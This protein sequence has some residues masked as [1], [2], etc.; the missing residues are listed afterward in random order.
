MKNLSL[1]NIAAACGGRYVGTAQAASQE[2]TGIETDSRKVPEGGMFVAIKG[3]RVD[4]HKFIEQVMQGGAATVLTEI[5]LGEKPYPYILVESTLQAVKDIA[6]FYL[7]GLNIPVVG[8]AGSVGKTSTKEM[9]HSVLSQG[10]NALK[11][12]GNFNNELGLPIT[13]FRL[14]DEQLAVLEMGISDF[15]EMHRL[16]KVARPHTVIMTNIGCCHLENLIDRDGILRAKSEIFD[17]LEPGAHIILNGDDDK[18]ATVTEVRGIKPV[19]FGLDAKNDFWAS[20]LRSLGLKGTACRIHTPVGDFDAT[21]GM[22]GKH[23]VYNALAGAAAGVAYGLTL[24]QIKAGIESNGSLAGRFNIIDTERYTIIDD[25]YNANPV[26]MKASLEVLQDGANRRVAI[27]GDMGELG[28][29][30]RALHA[31]VGTYAAGL[32]LDAIYC[33]GPLCEALVQAAADGGFKG[34][35]KHYATRDDLMAALPA[36]LQQGDTILVK[37][38]HFMQFPAIVEMLK[39]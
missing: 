38:S 27:L 29:D 3:E 14:R 15:G 9:T 31:G 12:Q 5:D 28:T 23:M 37:A 11:T 34:E 24:E 18:L 17:F 8:I 16:A 30:E 36:L 26:S 32:D 10:F 13:I 20:D 4:G 33:A 1:A 2:V 25:C 19:T 39:G 6:E 35:V 7:K 21:V 22:P